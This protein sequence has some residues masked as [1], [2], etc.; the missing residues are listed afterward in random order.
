MKKAFVYLFIYSI[1]NS[2]TAQHINYDDVAVIINDNSQPSIE[3][4]NYFKT[5]RNIPDLNMI[6]I[7]CSTQERVDSVEL[8][9][10]VN[11]VSDY[12]IN[13]NLSESINY[14]VTTKGV[15][16]VFEG[17]NCDS[18]P[19]L[20]KCSSIESELTLIINQSDKIGISQT[21]QNPYFESENY[22]FKQNEQDIFLV[23]R[24]DGYTIDD[25]KALI[26]R[27]GPDLYVNKDDAQFIFDLAFAQDSASTVPMV[28]IL[29]S[30]NDLVQSKNWNSIYDPYPSTFITNESNVLGYYSYIY[31]PS[32]K[33]LNYSWLAGSIANQGIGETAFTFNK[34]ENIYNDLIIANLIEE[35]VCGASGTVTLYFLSQG[36]VWPEVLFDRYTYGID[37]VSET[38]PYFNLAESYWASIRVLSSV[39][40]VMGDPK[41][42]IRRGTPNDIPKS[43]Q[44]SYFNIFPIPAKNLLTVEYT[45]HNSQ[46]V[47]INIFNMY[48]SR[49]YNDY[50]TVS[51]ARESQIIDISDLKT[52]I[53]VVELISGN[54]HIRKKILI[55]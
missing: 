50:Y 21:V 49:V 8:F 54:K 29:E 51:S 55:E 19:S 23:T 30:G 44:I 32:N 11:Q 22:D 5:K 52:G 43:N 37:T 31:Q 3:V 36:T 10:V 25:I 53:Y 13:N 33:I 34:D 38:N 26:D 24:L 45:I 42:S 16:L 27:S 41:T 40:V 47:I 20:I 14:L 6:H 1:F 28:S 7:N 9:S 18:V 39:H 15:P 2:L 12:L 17:G 48:G 4:G 46:Q 35:G